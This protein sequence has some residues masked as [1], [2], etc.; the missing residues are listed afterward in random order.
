MP[1]FV[2]ERRLIQFSTEQAAPSAD[3]RQI[4]SDGTSLDVLRSVDQTAQH[5]RLRFW[6]NFSLDVDCERG[7]VTDSSSSPITV[8]TLR[9]LVDDL[10][11]P[12]MIA[13]DGE[14]VVHA[15]AVRVADE[16]F[17]FLGEAGRGKS[18]LT[19]GFDRA[20]YPL[21]GD[22]AVILTTI[23]DC[24]HAEAIYP[25]LRL[26]PDSIAALLPAVTP[27]EPMSEFSSKQRVLGT[28]P[29]HEPLPVGCIFVLAPPSVDSTISFRRLTQAE[30]C[31]ALVA[32]SFALDPTDPQRARARL[33]DASALA[34]RV[35]VFEV[36]YSRDYARLPELVQQI[37][38]QAMDVAA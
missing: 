26:M 2:P 17:L 30:A 14:F 38:D 19:A 22:D 36:S 10:I 32:N 18:T 33:A 24:G 4:W 8:A 35:P 28:R 6:G 1:S 12:R 15:G 11:A 27:S 23:A 5:F 7:T 20:G 37:V 31:M 16:A 29:T 3:F 13:H 34:C 25:S 9:H 21:I